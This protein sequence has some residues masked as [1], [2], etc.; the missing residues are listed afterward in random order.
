MP[1][2]DVQPDRIGPGRD[3]REDPVGVGD[4]ADLDGRPARDVGRIVGLR[5]GGD[6]GSRRQRPDPPPGPAPRRRARRRTRAP[7]SGRRC[8]G[9][10]D[11][12]FGDDEPVVG[13]ELAQPRGPVD[14]DLERAQV[15]VVEPDQP[16]AAGEGAVELA[17]V[18]DL[19]ERL[20]ADL[21]RPLDQPREP[22]GRMEDR[23]QQDEV[24]AGRAEHREL[25]LL[26]HEVL[27]Q[28]RDGDGGP[29]RP[30][31]VD[32]TAEPVRLAQDR[33]RR[34]AAGLVGAGARD[35]VLVGRG[36]PAGRR[37]RALDLGDEVEAR[38]R[39]G[40]RRSAAARASA[41][42]PR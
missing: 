27:G 33:D 26:D 34:R 29:D 19:D 12:R 5:T 2:D 23:E 40:V 18:V 11:A 32:R 13:H 42:R 28:D 30:Q 20:E 14:V 31:V 21:E 9:L 24:G 25:D 8:A 37:R 3:R 6:E 4:A 36:D 17:R 35:D 38:A 7:A 1:G 10:A 39:R 15:A 22:L 16:G 41:R